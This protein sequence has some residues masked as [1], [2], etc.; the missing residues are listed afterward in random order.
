MKSFLETIAEDLQKKYGRDM[1]RIA[2][3]FPNRRAGVFMDGYLGRTAG[4]QPIWAPAYYSINDFFDWLCPLRPDNPIVSVILL[5]Q[6]YYQE[7]QNKQNGQQDISFFYSWGQQLLDDFNNIDKNMADPKQ[8]LTNASEIWQLEELTDKEVK[9]RLQNIFIHAGAPGAENPTDD[10]MAVSAARQEFTTVWNHLYPIYCN[11]TQQLQKRG[12]ATAGMRSR[13]V[14]EHLEDGSMSLPDQYDAYAFI[15]FNQLMTTEYRLMKFL[16]KEKKALFYWDCDA[17]FMNR[18]D[19]FHF[20]HTLERN[21]KEFPGEIP[22]WEQTHVNLQQI[23]FVSTTSDNAQASFVTQWLSQPDNLGEEEHRTAIVLCNEALLESVLHAIP[24]QRSPEG[25]GVKEINVTKGYPLGNTPAYSFVA[26]YL[27]RYRKQLLSQ[28]MELLNQLAEDIRKEAYDVLSHHAP[29]TWEGHLYAES[30]FRCHSVVTTMAMIVREY[31]LPD[32]AEVLDNLLMQTLRAQQ[33]PFKGEPSTG[34][35][36]MGMLETRNL[37]FDHILM[38]SV[39]EGYVPRKSVDHSFLP[40]DLRKAFHLVTSEQESEV[41]AYNFFRLMHRAKSITYVYNSADDSHAEKSRFLQQIL[42]NTELKVDMR[43]LKAAGKIVP[44]E[45]EGIAEEEVKQLR[46][47]R[48]KLSPTAL[49]HYLGCP[50]AFYFQDV[51]RLQT[52]Y[53]KEMVLAANTLGSIFHE[54]IQRCFQLMIQGKKRDEYGY[55]VSPAD[56]LNL[57]DNPLLIDKII[58]EAFEMT[59]K[60]Q[61]RQ[62]SAAERKYLGIESENMFLTNEHAMEKAVVH[63]YLVNTLRFDTRWKGLHIVDMETRH[64]TQVGQWAIGGFVDRLDVAEIEGTMSL[65]VVDYKTGSFHNDSLTVNLDQLFEGKSNVYA[66]Q[67]FIYCHACMVKEQN[68]GHERPIA[69]VLLFVQKTGNSP[70]ENAL[71]EGFNPYLVLVHDKEEEIITDYRQQ[72]HEQFFPQLKAV[73]EKMQTEAYSFLP[74]DDK[75]CAFCPFALLGGDSCQ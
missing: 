35:Q 8:I 42:V 21:I 60:M 54:A 70:T 28:P 40:Y 46:E 15:G 3:I 65:R 25:T 59:G 71:E 36:I 33:V 13:Y 18:S 29:D 11:F 39:S 10:T 27:A 20:T 1:S 56:I 19:C 26:S 24:A 62:L 32:I 16:Y 43:S 30:F 9:E 2:L 5:F 73:V 52:P 47:E 53:T 63:R 4:S 50:M 49:S 57:L 58:N 41:Y 23:E 12:E 72:V 7:L 61:Y 66:L 68:A 34:L 44:F 67:T 38:L 51:A 37:D 64:D 75:K 17:F 6:A 69:P 22:T 31:P 55:P 74:S 14:V 45:Y 48:D